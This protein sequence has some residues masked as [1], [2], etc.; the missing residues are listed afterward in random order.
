MSVTERLS[1]V[2][3]LQ[4]IDADYWWGSF[5]YSDVMGRANNRTDAHRQAVHHKMVI[6]GHLQPHAIDKGR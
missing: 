4:S 2:D 3:D 6:A 1:E 5:T